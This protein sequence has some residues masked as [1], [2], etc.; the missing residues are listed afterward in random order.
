MIRAS[1]KANIADSVSARNSSKFEQLSRYENAYDFY[2]QT[3]FSTDSTLGHLQGIDFSQPVLVTQL[4]PGTNYVQYTL[5][6]NVGN[7]FAPIGTS[8]NTLGINPT[9]RVSTIFTPSQPLPERQ[10]T[11]A[12]ITDN[13]TQPSNSFSASG[14]GTQLFV[15]NKQLMLKVP[16]P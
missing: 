6:G 4:N 5:N 14:S 3:G 9:G 11:A 1:V 7:Y 13:W 2:K 15:P 8:V 16:N 10:S 12:G